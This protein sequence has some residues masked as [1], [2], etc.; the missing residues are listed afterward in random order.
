[1]APRIATNPPPFQGSVLTPGNPGVKVEGNLLF[2][3]DNIYDISGTFPIQVGSLPGLNFRSTNGALAL[4]DTFQGGPR[5]ADISDPAH[6]RF[7]SV[8]GQAGITL[9]GYNAAW[10]GN[11][12]YFTEEAGGIAI[13]DASLPGGT[14]ISARHWWNQFLRDDRAGPSG[15][16]DERVCRDGYQ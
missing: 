7:L 11:L 6:P 12:L 1:V 9:G 10:A 13:Y 3:G 4:S 14:G 16:G 15:L 2:A 8:V 5:V